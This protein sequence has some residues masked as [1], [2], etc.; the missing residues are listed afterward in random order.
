MQLG[1][2]KT[3]TF[4]GPNDEFDADELNAISDN[5]KKSGLELWKINFF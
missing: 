5:G 1:S 2:G 3:Y 4:F